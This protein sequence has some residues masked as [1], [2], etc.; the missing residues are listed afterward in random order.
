MDLNTKYKRVRNLKIGQDRICIY[1]LRLLT[2]QIRSG[3]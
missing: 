2:Y 1:P 3:I